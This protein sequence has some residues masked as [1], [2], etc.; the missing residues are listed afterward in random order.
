[1]ETLTRVAD[2]AG[3]TDSSSE[4]E[5]SDEDAGFFLGGGGTAFFTETKAGFDGT[6]CSSSELSLS[7]SSDV[8]FAGAAFAE[9]AFAA[10]AAFTWKALGF[11]SSE[12]LSLLS[13]DETFLI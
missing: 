2:F 6:G 4:D 12:S 3:G 1:L 8:L 10:G 13:S 11:S 5:S 9:A 7:E